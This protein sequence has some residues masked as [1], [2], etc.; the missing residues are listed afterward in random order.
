MCERNVPGRQ[1]GEKCLYGIVSWGV[2]C[3]TE[4]IPGVYTR[5][6]GLTNNSDT[7]CYLAS[8]L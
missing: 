3:A 7:S 6:R 1:V 4:G 2:G 5:V 8:F